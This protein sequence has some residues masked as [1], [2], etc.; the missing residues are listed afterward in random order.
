MPPQKAGMKKADPDFP[1]ER[2]R[3]VFRQEILQDG[4][5]R[6]EAEQ[7]VQEQGD[8]CPQKRLLAPRKGTDGP[9][10][11]HLPTPVI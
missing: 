3:K 1:V 6:Q 10:D 8:A 4:W 9:Q 11:P 7:G 2:F 5:G